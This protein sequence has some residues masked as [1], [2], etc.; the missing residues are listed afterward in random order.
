MLD[1]LNPTVRPMP[2]GVPSATSSSIPNPIADFVLT[3][4]NWKP[5][6]AMSGQLCPIVLGRFE[7]LT[8]A[9]HEAIDRADAIDHTAMP[10]ILAILD[11]DERLVLA[12]ALT[13][14]GIAWCFPVGSASGARQ[15]V[16][17]AC[18]LR[19]QARRADQGQHSSIARNLRFRAELLEARLVDPLWR[20]FAAQALALAA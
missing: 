19:A 2:V 8:D 3:L 20:A 6:A 17:E 13:K 16:A 11:R 7:T 5:A 15:V 1:L 10:C 4:P 9:M 12:G 18:A 14:S